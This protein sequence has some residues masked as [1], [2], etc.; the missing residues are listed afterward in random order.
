MKETLDYREKVIFARLLEDDVDERAA[1]MI[2][3]TQFE[4]A[5]DLAMSPAELDIY[6]PGHG[7]SLSD[8]MHVSDVL[9]ELLEENSAP[10]VTCPVCG[11]SAEGTVLEMGTF[12]LAHQAFHLHEM[13]LKPMHAH[14]EEE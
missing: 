9:E 12:L 1:R 14:E 4:V 11:E 5:G 8:M 2:A 3:V 10:S 7:L 6:V 13:N